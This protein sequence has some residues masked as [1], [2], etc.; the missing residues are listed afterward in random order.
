VLVPDVANILLP[1]FAHLD[2]RS[3]HLFTFPSKQAYPVRVTSSQ[4]G[5]A[6]PVQF[7]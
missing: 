4:K 1:N 2:I 7:A 5:P 6:L 3:E